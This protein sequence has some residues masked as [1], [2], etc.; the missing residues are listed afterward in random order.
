DYV[1]NHIG[2]D[3]LYF[4]A[5]VWKLLTTDQ[6]L[7]DLGVF[8]KPAPVP[9]MNEWKASWCQEGK[10]NWLGTVYT[11]ADDCKLC[12]TAIIDA[13]LDEEA[14]KG[15]YAVTFID[16][17]A[18]PKVAAVGYSP[19]GYPLFLF[20][21]QGIRAALQLALDCGFCAN[22]QLTTRSDKVKDLFDRILDFKEYNYFE[23]CEF[24]S[25]SVCLACLGL[26]LFKHYIIT[27]AED[28]HLLYTVIKEI[29]ELR[30]KFD[31]YVNVVQN[32]SQASIYLG[33]CYGTP[34][35]EE[36]K[37]FRLLDGEQQLYE[38][39]IKPD[40]FPKELEDILY[41]EC[42]KGYRYYGQEI[43]EAKVPG[44][45]NNTLSAPM[46]FQSIRRSREIRADW[47][48]RGLGS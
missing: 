41:D 19:K 23:N 39:V 25:S 9:D 1:D 16:N 15:G 12:N 10:P 22:I 36:L 18:R 43:I 2:M 33:K 26:H 45:I 20:Q 4:D 37:L 6:R 30:N 42:F 32:L 8:Y 31:R 7:K 46:L 40:K 48:K 35:T 47:E 3:T 21:L 29:L 38:M 17:Y 44:A 28:F 14:G 27:E 34:T 13:F 24:N 11:R 5:M